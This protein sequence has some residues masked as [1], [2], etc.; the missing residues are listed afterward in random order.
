M[1]ARRLAV[2]VRSF[3]RLSQTFVLSELLALERLGVDLELFA[4]TNPRE[5][6]TQPEVADLR[7]PVH[8]LDGDDA[9]AH[10][11]LPPRAYLRGVVVGREALRKP[12]Y[13]AASRPDCVRQALRLA[14]LL[15]ERKI[16]HIHAHFA[17]D[18]TL[19][20]LL[21]S[22]MVGVP[23]SFTAH[24]R[25]LYQLAPSALA[26]RVRQA[27]RVVTCCQANV[28]YLGKVLPEAQNIHLVPHGVDV[29]RF[30]PAATT[31]PGLIV[32]VGRLVGK[33]GFPVLLSACRLLADSGRDFR[34]VVYG[35]GPLRRELATSIERM[36]LTD[37]VRLAGARTQGELARVISRARIFALTPVVEADGDRDG[38]PNV[39]LEGMAC[40]VPVVS[41]MV[42]GI[43]E[44]VRHMANGLLAEPEDA[45]AIAGHLAAL[46]DDD[47]LRRRLGVGARRTAVESYDARVWAKRLASTILGEAEQVSPGGAW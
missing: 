8:Y 45:E 36:G 27:A 22:R 3:P 4:L 26:G 11:R 38:V 18:P 9:R 21:A 28:D 1:S 34:C 13:A 16:S 23:F 46:L 40:G 2:V 6:I 44:A 19:V 20:A 32:S 37:R 43:P 47:A 15:L 12:G 42:G 24:A 31:H 7:A 29:E 17:H 5:V 14:P 33:K 41:T 10:L 39:V 25:D 35:D 30:R